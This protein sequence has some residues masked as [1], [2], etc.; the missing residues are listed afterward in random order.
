MRIFSVSTETLL[1]E[2][3][4]AG[5][6]RLDLNEEFLEVKKN[7]AKLVPQLKREG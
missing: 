6:S 3:A 1:Y 5:D 7:A 2:I 4:C